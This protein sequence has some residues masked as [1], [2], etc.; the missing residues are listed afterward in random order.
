MGNYN[1]KSHILRCDNCY[2]IKKMT[3]FPSVPNS[4]INLE[5]RCNETKETLQNFLFQLN[6]GSPYKIICQIC[7]KEFKNS[8][9]C[10]DCNHIYCQTCIKDHLKHKNI[11][12]SKVD[13]FCVYHQKEL[14]CSYCHECSI[15]I[16]KKC[17]QEKKH[18]NHQ[19]SEFNKL[20]KSKNDKNYLKEKFRLAENKISFTTQLVSAF[21]KKLKKEEDKNIMATAEK[22]NT[23]QNKSILELAKF[24][25][26]LYDNTKHKNYNIIYNFIENTNLNVNKFKFSENNISLEAAFK[27]I[28]NYL[29]EDFIII[30]NDDEQLINNNEKTDIKRNK[31]L[32]EFE[33]DDDN[34]I[35]PSNT[36]V[37][38]AAF[39]SIKLNLKE[40]NF[41][42]DDLNSYNEQSIRN[43]N[44]QILLQ[45]L[46][47]LKSNNKK[48]DDNIEEEEDNDQ[49]DNDEQ[50]Y[51]PRSHA[52][53]IPTKVIQEQIKEKK[54]KE[55]NLDKEKNIENNY[56]MENNN[57]IWN[58]N[59]ND[60]KEGKKEENEKE[61]NNKDEKEEK[62]DKIENEKDNI[63]NKNDIIKNKV[64][65]IEDEEDKIENEGDEMENEENKLENKEENKL[66]EKEENKL[67]EKIDEIKI[68][69]KKNNKGIKIEKICELKSNK[70]AKFI[71]INR[72]R[73]K[74]SS[75]INKMMINGFRNSKIY[76]I[77][78]N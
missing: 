2:S 64:D 48:C 5:C 56:E 7:K 43:S 52:I 40:D 69:P 42:K 3:I 10:H 39:N 28:L 46:K 20:M 16:C 66:E 54:R 45:S 77:M 31:S 13:F 30:R 74:N 73:N 29:K 53:F 50:H 38:T 75:I 34:Y 51:R 22:N 23:I 4:Y 63:E 36:I 60:E 76:N 14:F 12:I 44:R 78:I 59:I 25:I 15:N 8:F 19:C 61:E 17:I 68:D 35:A 33:N 65:K 67:E 21:L 24:F 62:E 41:D 57:E 6:K 55:L 47:S 26:Y 11:P 37:G 1:L 27:K 70:Y 49:N 18:L 58:L 71:G 32:W 9:Y 72:L